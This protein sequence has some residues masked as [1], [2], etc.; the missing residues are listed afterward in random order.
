MCKV[1]LLLLDP[2]AQRILAPYRRGRERLE[3]E[4]YG[5][6]GASGEC[7]APRRRSGAPTGA[8]AA[9][10]EAGAWCRWRTR[11]SR[12]TIVGSGECPSAA[13]PAAE[14]V[15]EEA[16][17]RRRRRRRL[18][19]RNWPSQRSSAGLNGAGARR[20]SFSAWGIPRG[21]D[22]RALRRAEVV[23]GDQLVLGRS[24]DGQRAWTSTAEVESLPPAGSSAEAASTQSNN[25]ATTWPGSMCKKRAI[26]NRGAYVIA[27]ARTFSKCA[28]I[29]GRCSLR[30]DA[31]TRTSR[32]SAGKPST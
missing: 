9:R 32:C 7:G 29:S 17:R 11:R 13:R 28:A 20:R 12:T 16:L 21:A 4:A 25:R 27:S 6:R 3:R 24:N 1:I 10:V 15:E 14:G 2:T 18:R 30:S 5:R 26:K 31:N 19:W 23:G 22:E 8:A